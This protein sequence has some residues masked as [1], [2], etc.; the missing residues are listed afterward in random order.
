MLNHGMGHLCLHG[1][2]AMFVWMGLLDKDFRRYIKTSIV[3]ENT[4]CPE[5]KLLQSRY[6][7]EHEISSQCIYDYLLIQL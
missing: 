5:Q 4:L 2:W 6:F 3:I 1:V 7:T